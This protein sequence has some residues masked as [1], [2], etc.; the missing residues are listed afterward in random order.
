ML[1]I[2]TNNYKISYDDSI[3]SYK[4]YTNNYL[5]TE[6]Y[7]CYLY[8]RFKKFILKIRSKENVNDLD[9]DNFISLVY[10]YDVVSIF[11]INHKSESLFDPLF[12]SKS[13]FLEDNI[14]NYF[15]KNCMPSVNSNIKKSILQ[16]LPKLS[17]K[18]LKYYNK[19]KKN[20]IKFNNIEYVIKYEINDLLVTINLEIIKN[21][22]IKVKYKKKINMSLHIFNHLVK[23]YNTKMFNNYESSNTLDDKVIEYIYIIFL[24]Y[25]TLSSGNNQASILPSFKK[26]IKETLNIKIELFGS[27]LN[28]SS[29]TFGSLFYDIDYVFGSIGNYFNTK[30]SKG[31]Y[32]INPVFDKCLIDDLI[33]KCLS[34][35]NLA[36]KNNN[37]L[38]FLFTLPI[39]YNRYSNKLNI[40]NKYKKF[41]IILTKEKFPYI[42]YNRTFL[43]TIVSPIVNTHILIFHNDYINEYV[44]KNVINFKSIINNWQ[45]KKIKNNS[46]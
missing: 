45:M 29:F 43:K 17:N 18:Y 38:L 46:D 21:D 42:R 5:I 8:K 27:P 11:I 15:N 19:L 44:K 35:L 34:E 7:R 9:K 14:K 2:N 10:L 30:L 39:S 31:N 12:D 32:E 13:P 16:I 33:N 20:I 41:E 23:L 6:I 3:F 37:G 1:E 22:L 24:R 26:L 28:T 36:S 40:L 4:K 25:G